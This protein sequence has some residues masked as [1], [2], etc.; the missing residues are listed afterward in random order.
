MWCNQV[1]RVLETYGQVAEVSEFF[2]SMEA[3]RDIPIIKAAIAYDDPQSGETVILIIN[4]PLY[5]GGQLQQ[6]LLNP[7]QIRS[8]DIQVN[9]A[10][11]HLSASS[12]HSIL[13]KEENLV[14]PLNLKGILSYFK[15][16]TPTMEEIENC[17]HVTLTEDDEW[18]PYSP[19][20]EDLENLA[21][22]HQSQLVISAINTQCIE[23]SDMVLKSVHDETERIQNASVKVK[24]KH[25]IVEDR[26]LATRWAI[27]LK[28]ASNTIKETTQKFVR[29]SL[30]TIKRRYR[31][32]QTTLRYN[33][34]RCRFSSDT[35]FSN[36]KS[37]LQNTCA[38]LFMTDFGYGKITPMKQK[39]EA[40][41]ALKELIQDVGIPSDIHTDGAK[42]LTQ[43]SW[44]QTCK[45]MGIK[46][47]K[48]E[49]NS[50]WQNRTEVEIRDLKKH[51]KRLMSRTAAWASRTWV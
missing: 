33:Q 19:H 29:S 26:E 20:F 15:V 7:N 50:P 6:M 37:I 32:K 17:Q 2:D 18:N 41:H 23:Y 44:K 4:Q 14:I 13:V 12:S 51:V 9:D 48:T 30:H 11:K 42:E 21:K 3:L 40:G 28:D 25:L 34:L 39:S 22:N 35:F 45:D 1:A 49:K 36:T 10:P 46:I 8:N 47:T 16:R 38:Q 43:G 5:F 31:T 24:N 27:G